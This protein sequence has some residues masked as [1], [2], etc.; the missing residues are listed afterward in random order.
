ML[1][2]LNHHIAV[3]P[4]TPETVAE[5]CF[6]SEKEEKETLGRPRF[7]IP[8]EMLEELLELGFSWIKIGEILGVS[9]WT[10]HR[11][12]EKYG[13]QNIAGFHHLPDEE[14]RWGVVVSTTTPHR[15]AV[16][17]GSIL[18]MLSFFFEF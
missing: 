16:F 11:R 13:L 5:N 12:I 18:A 17:C 15:S 9:M 4:I 6:A 10:F 8:R 1:S 14:L 7:D 3:E 2:S